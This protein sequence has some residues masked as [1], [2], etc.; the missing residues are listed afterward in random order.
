MERCKMILSDRHFRRQVV[1]IALLLLAALI[2]GELT[3][4]FM[5]GDYK[6]DRIEHDYEIAGYLEQNGV[7]P[8]VIASA[9]TS[10]KDAADRETGASLLSVSGYDR[11]VESRLLPEVW[12]F[13]NKYM[14]ISLVAA[15]LFSTA[16]LAALCLGELRR[17][18][19]IEAASDQLR[20]FMEGDAAARLSDCGEG[21]LEGL[22]AAINTMATSLTAHAEKEKQSKEFLKD[23]ISDISHQLK[24]PLAAL[25]MYNEIICGEKTGNE[26][27][28]NFA[29]KSSRE[30]SRMESLIQ[31]LL[32]LA[33]LDAGAITLEKGLHP[34]GRFLEEIVSSFAARAGL[35]GKTISVHCDPSIQM[36]FD[37]TWLG[38]SVGNI[39][40]NA[41][42]HTEN[43]DRID[44]ACT[45]TAV[46]TEIMI[47][48]SGA[49]IHPEDIHH[50]FKKFYRSRYS[51]DKQGVGIGLALSKMIVEKHGGAITVRSELG[52]GAQFSVVF[53]KLTNL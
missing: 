6:T 39:L 43:G 3:V 8:T 24:T 2:A 25:I 30:L 28:E 34:V 22:F 36:A 17:S 5:S 7:D 29:A 9:F 18:R 45:E 1:T 50:I 32:K 44:I 14:T 51:K 42:D 11:Q 16:I 10:G 41:L 49:G 53:P 47:R 20:R 12:H 15:L 19:Q 52:R 31:N 26:V 35:E 23:T 13:R 27:V 21:G 4:V 46:A 38:E 33:R 40:K 48:D 37:E